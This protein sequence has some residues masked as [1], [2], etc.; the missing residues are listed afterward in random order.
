MVM[1]IGSE[2]LIFFSCPFSFRT[3][4]LTPVPSVSLEAAWNGLTL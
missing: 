1:V 3:M 2:P 4:L